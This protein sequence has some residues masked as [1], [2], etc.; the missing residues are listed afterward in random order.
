MSKIDHC[1]PAA[2]RSSVPK[3]LEVLI[4]VKALFLKA[5]RHLFFSNGGGAAVCLLLEIDCKMHDQSLR[6]A[7]LQSVVGF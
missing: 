1:A 4:N 6:L 5:C 2:G 3:T 7:T